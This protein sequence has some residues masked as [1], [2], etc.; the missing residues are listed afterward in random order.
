[1]KKVVGIIR[2]ECGA[3]TGL[4]KIYDQDEAW[5]HTDD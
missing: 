4:Q 5:I 3:I 2:N 1:M